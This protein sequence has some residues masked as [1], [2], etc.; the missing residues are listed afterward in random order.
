MAPTP[1][2]FNR[3]AA[4]G[5]PGHGLGEK[6][7]RTVWL[8][9]DLTGVILVSGTV[10]PAVM[11]SLEHEPQPKLPP[12][13]SGDDEIGP[14]G[15]TGDRSAVPRARTAIPQSGRIAPGRQRRRAM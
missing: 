1:R 9:R 6:P 14:G 12:A 15:Q 2:C 7:G 4:G 3:I 11:P 10:K 13:G 8:S 5:N